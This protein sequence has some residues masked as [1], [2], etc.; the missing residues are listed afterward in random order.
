MMVL[1][2]TDLPE[3]VAPAM[4]MCGALVEV[5]DHRLARR[6]APQ[7]QRQ[8]TALAQLRADDDA[9]QAD[10]RFHGIGHFEA[11][12]GTARHRSLDPDGRCSQRQRQIV[13]QADD[14]INAHL[15]LLT[16]PL[17]IEW[18][19]AKLGDR[20]P[21]L[22]MH[23]AGRHVE[24]G[25]SAQDDLF[26]QRHVGVAVGASVRV[27]QVDRRQAGRPTRR[28]GRSRRWFCW[29]GSSF[30]FGCLDRQ[31]VLA[32]ALA[33]LWRWG[34]AAR[35]RGVGW[36]SRRRLRLGRGGHKVGRV[37]RLGVGCRIGGL[38]QAW[39]KTPQTRQRTGDGGGNINERRI[40]YQQ[41]KTC[42]R[43]ENNQQ[44]RQPIAQAGQQQAAQCPADQT[45]VLPIGDRNPSYD[46][47]ANDEGAHL[48]RQQEQLGAEQGFDAPI[49]G[50]VAEQQHGADDDACH[51]NQRRSPAGEGRQPGQRCAAR[52][53]VAQHP[54]EQ[55][56]AENGRANAEQFLAL[57]LPDVF[58]AADNVVHGWVVH[59]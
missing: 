11:H 21:G 38:L 51:S 39:G 2:Q 57:A 53:I 19:D 10:Q 26:Q 35:G 30:R 4:S 42:H 50:A 15:T 48:E 7:G 12:V 6:I 31:R 55:P 36:G 13:G 16:C 58:G 1:I 25:Q 27:Q 14:A 8:D 41:C 47:I 9:A 45:T 34:L 49:P 43:H 22:H 29:R 23:H 46:R 54:Q 18:L 20:R 52:W 5:H 33:P 3:P 37:V 59:G 28:A 40:A 17:D 56:E 32:G 24:I 44:Q